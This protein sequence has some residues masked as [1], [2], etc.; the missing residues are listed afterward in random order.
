VLTRELRAIGH[1]IAISPLHVKPNNLAQTVRAIRA[2][3][4]VV[5]FGITIPHKIAVS[6]LIDELSPQAKLGGSVNFV[7]REANGRL[8]GDNLDGAG[9]AEPWL[10]AMAQ[11]IRLEGA[12][13]VVM[14]RTQAAD[15]AINQT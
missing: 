5:G 7:R 10:K 15:T 6:D 11:I 13:N 12:A 1:D 14:Q 2:F 4:N 8:F 3:Q 9:Y